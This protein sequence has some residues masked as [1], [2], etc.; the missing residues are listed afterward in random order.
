MSVTNVVNTNNQQFTNYDRSKLLLGFNQFITGDVTASGDDVEIVEGM[1][2]GRIAATEKLV[3]ADKD[4]TDGSQIPVGLA[5]V[6]ETVT[7]GTTKTIN[8]VNKGRVDSSKINFADT[9]TLATTIGP[10]NNKRT[11]KDYLSDLG[12]ILESGTEL[13]KVDNQ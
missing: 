6:T 2:I 4:A 5:V 3:P 7:D 8:L 1:V 10:T 13:T 11:F 9:E 12:L